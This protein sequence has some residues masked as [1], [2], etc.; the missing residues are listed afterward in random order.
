MAQLNVSPFVIRTE[1]VFLVGSVPELRNWSPDNA[2]PL[3]SAN[4]PTWSG[5]YSNSNLDLFFFGFA[6]KIWAYSDR[7]VAS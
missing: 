7:H 6:D 4:Y 2:I 1:N 5:E 3:S